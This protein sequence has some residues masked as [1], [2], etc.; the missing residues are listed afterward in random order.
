[1]RADAGAHH[2][3]AERALISCL[4]SSAPSSTPPSDLRG[5]QLRHVVSHAHGRKARIRRKPK[6]GERGLL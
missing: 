1:V 2:A 4:R 6:T 3:A 5:R